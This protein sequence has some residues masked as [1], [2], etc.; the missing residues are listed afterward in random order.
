MKNMVKIFGV[1]ALVAIIAFSFTAC[2]GDDGGGGGGGKVSEALQGTWKEDGDEYYLVF[3]KDSFGT[4]QTVAAAT[5]ACGSFIATSDN[6]SKIEF[7]HKEFGKDVTGSITYSITGS[8]LT[9]SDQSGGGTF[10]ATMGTWT[11]Q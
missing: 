11:K 2:G 10:Q 5:G 3:T 7:Q 9:V 4:G 1:I 8:K 6:G